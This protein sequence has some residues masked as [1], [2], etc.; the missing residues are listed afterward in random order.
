MWWQ[1]CGR[2]DKRPFSVRWKSHSFR[3]LRADLITVSWTKTGFLRCASAQQRNPRP[4]PVG[5]GSSSTNPTWLLSKVVIA[6][7]CGKETLWVNKETADELKNHLVSPTKHTDRQ[8]SERS[9]FSSYAPS[10]I[11]SLEAFMH[12]EY[13]TGRSY[14]MQQTSFGKKKVY[15]EEL[16]VMDLSYRLKNMEAERRVNL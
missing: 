3:G 8:R 5:R 4:T 16:E 2:T 14:I 15:W 11:K 12:S 13:E 7:Q 1:E 10:P 9:S 6:G